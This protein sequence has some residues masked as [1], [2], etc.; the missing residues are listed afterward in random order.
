MPVQP[1]A[2]SQA[3][4][5]E[6]APATALVGLGWRQPHYQTLL[7]QRPALAFLEVHSENYFGAGGAALAVLEQGRSHYPISLHGVGLSL[8]AAAGLDGWHLNQLA[9]LVNRIE[10]VRV[11]DHASFARG[12][13]ANSTV[14][15]ADLL[16]LP[17]TPEALDVLCRNVQQVQERLQRRLLVENLSAYVQWHVPAGHT[18]PEP[19]FLLRLTRRSGCALLVDV[20]NIYVNAQNAQIAGHCDDPLLAC[21]HWLNQIPPDAVGELHLAGHCRVTDEH[22][23][24][25][26]D[27]HGSRVSPPV[28]ALYR[29]A[30]ARFGSVPTLIEWDTALPPLPVLLDEVALCTSPAKRQCTS[31]AQQQSTAHMPPRWLP[32]E[33]ACRTAASPAASP[34]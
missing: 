2:A 27:D 30:L 13:Y 8:G 6:T 5:P 23:D 22:G 24:I 12:T 29:H 25:V 9:R 7:E 28:W 16:P 33:S 1:A 19:E 15:A 3:I 4:P 21:K 10:P 26:I 34:V 20:N 14:H 32:H 11:S 31:P 18:L 17:F